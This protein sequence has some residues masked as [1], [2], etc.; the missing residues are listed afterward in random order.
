M[1]RDP[2]R[3]AADDL[4]AEVVRLPPNGAVTV[5]NS[6]E[7]RYGVGPFSIQKRDANG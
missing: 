2:R 1:N 4:V 5:R 3:T 6:H 7:F